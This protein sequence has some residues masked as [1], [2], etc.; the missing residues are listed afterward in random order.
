M[1]LKRSQS[2]TTTR[3]RGHLTIIF[4]VMACM[5]V[6]MFAREA[7]SQTGL[8]T[9]YRQDDPDGQRPRD[10]PDCW[11]ELDPN[12]VDAEKIYIPVDGSI[13]FGIENDYV[14]TNIK[15]FQLW[16]LL[17][18]ASDAKHLDD[19]THDPP[20]SAGGHKPDGTPIPAEDLV[21]KANDYGWVYVHVKFDPQPE[22]EWIKLTNSHTHPISFKIVRVRTDTE[23]FAVQR[24]QSNESGES[25]VLDVQDASF[26]IEDWMVNETRITQIEIYPERCTVDAAAEPYFNA[27]PS[28]GEWFP[29]YTFIDPRGDFRPTG[30]LRWVCF[31]EGLKAQEIYE[32]TVPLIGEA[33]TT[34]EMFA[35]DEDA[36]E[37]QE[38]LV[39]LGG[40][41]WVE[42]F[43]HYFAENGMH[44]QRD[45]EGWGGDPAFDALTSEAHAC[46]DTLSVN[47]K[48]QADLVYPFTGA[49]SDNWVFSAQV[50]VPEEMFE[51]S[52]FILLNTYP[53]DP[54]H[55]EHWSL[56]LELNGG[57]GVL[58][59]YN[60]DGAIPL[61]KG[62]WAEIRVEIDL[63][64]DEQSV[65][66]EG[67]HLVTK[68]WSDGVAPG[69][70]LNI[71]A[72]DLY[73]AG[74][75]SVYYDDLVL[76]HGEMSS[77]PADLN[78]DGSVNT[79][80]LL[81]LLAAWGTEG[82]GDID[83]DGLVAT[84]D[85]LQLL[86]AWGDC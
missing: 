50:Y 28:T 6:S 70:A 56:Q 76:E 75:T 67:V 39:N 7:C 79:A 77:C 74:S 58:K 10:Y 30:G 66:Y 21:V 85:L 9:F 83:G 13:W 63:D 80:D 47:I 73:A 25:W 8:R 20:P 4:G 45:W 52:Y 33:D 2:D 5:I 18:P 38:F 71:G 55:P 31:G 49:D 36:G 48:G 1:D 37:Y 44:G 29:E 65:F 57:E 22:W 35:W 68:S 72:V 82:P 62:Q 12:G 32:M 19:K 23:C 3:S 41:P 26:G 34:Y 27:D 81:I 40:L 61:I 78:D 60:S 84:P 16:L 43:R 11:D 24:C 59:D 46:S 64:E 69:G 51:A 42:T 54:D 53:A 17:S 15:V 86:A 14:D